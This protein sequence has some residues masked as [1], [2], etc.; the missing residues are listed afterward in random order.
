[1][2]DV[3]AGI[4]KR[5]GGESDTDMD[6]ALGAGAREADEV[7]EERSK[8][9]RAP[10]GSGGLGEAQRV[11][12]ALN[13]SLGG[14]TK[15]VVTE[16]DQVIEKVTAIER[17][18][19]EHRARIM[20]LEQFMADFRAGTISCPS[21]KPNSESGRSCY[22]DSASARSGGLPPFFKRVELVVGGF[23]CDSP[24]DEVIR[25]LRK[26]M[27]VGESNEVAGVS[28]IF[29]NGPNVSNG[30]IKFATP[31]AMWSFIRESR[32]AEIRHKEQRLWWTVEKSVKERN[33]SKRISHALS[34]ITEAV[35]ERDIVPDDKKKAWVG[36]DW[37]KGEIW[38]RVSGGRPK[39]I[40][41]TADH[42]S[43]F[44]IVSA[45]AT[46]VPGIDFEAIAEKAN[47]HA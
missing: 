26:L 28:D 2:T 17:E 8:R 12:D 3:V 10:A 30:K 36:A 19:G 44:L 33:I 20:V 35:V 37:G 41:T 13:Q 42:E 18:L 22:D 11:I 31:G 38:V 6:G 43:T 46:Q 45:D 16:V 23:A 32:G 47:A 24:R 15:G 27:R 25:V 4:E 14:Q 39:T 7:S 1:M 9:R 29:T 40:L 21:V 34:A 5:A